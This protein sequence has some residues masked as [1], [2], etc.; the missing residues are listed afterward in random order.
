M[1]DSRSVVL[2]T[3]DSLR[4]DHCGYVDG[5]PTAAPAIE[6]LA[7]DGLAFKRAIAPGPATPESMPA[8]FTGR[9]PVGP[10]SETT[11]LAA[12]R[13]RLRRHMHARETLP[14]RLSR[15]GYATAAFTPNPFTSRGFGFDQG[16]DAFTDFIGGDERSPLYD[17]V[18]EGFLAGDPTSSL[19]RVLLN[20]WQR[21]EVFRPWE[22]YYDDAVAW[23][24]GAEEPYFLWLFLMDAH[25]PYLADGDHRRQS[26]LDQFYANV[27]FWRGSHET[28]FRSS[29]HD[30]L[31]TA[32]EDAVRYADDCVRRLRRDLEDATIVVHGDHG[33]AF[34]E[35]GTYGHEPYLHPENVHVPL[36][37]G[38]P[39]VT[40]RTV[41]RPV[42][43]RRLPEVVTAAATGTLG[44]IAGKPYTT[45]RTE[46]GDATGLYT[47][48]D[49]AVRTGRGRWGEGCTPPTDADGGS[50]VAALL[51]RASAARNEE[52]RVARAAQEVAKR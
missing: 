48:D 25:N 52:R 35:H 7:A 41:E 18:F 4:A 3:I 14:E 45:T 22:S 33:E 16:F 27:E 37:A 32:Y 20:F 5:S 2:V 15:L 43:L 29:V 47:A 31:V 9:Y 12:T 26:R 10:D 49:Y 24:R 30:R 36:A 13:Q 38:G 42:S 17:R 51:D 46:Q 28:P 6:E 40:S 8:T 39:G 44:T 11:D 1:T 50:A 21:E 23:A 34:G 19:A